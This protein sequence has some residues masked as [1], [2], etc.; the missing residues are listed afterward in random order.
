MKVLKKVLFFYFL[1][2]IFSLSVQ[3]K[4][5]TPIRIILHINSNISEGEYS[6]R[7]ISN[8]A[9]K[10]GIEGVIFTDKALLKWEYGIW[11]LRRIIKKTVEQPSVFNYGIKNYLED[12]SRLNKKFPDLVLIEGLEV[13]P[14]YYWEGSFFKG[15]LKMYNWHKHL[16]VLGLDEEGY[17]N[18][19]MIGNIRGLAKN[20]SFFKFW[21]L[22]IVGMGILFLN[23]KKYKY[24]DFQGRIWGEPLPGLNFLGIFLIGAGV[25]F[26]INN[27][28]FS[29]FRYTQYQGDLG[30]T[31]YQEFIDYVGERRGLVFWAEPEAESKGEFLGV[32]FESRP[33]IEEFLNTQGYT[34][35][36]VFYDGYREIG[37]P[38]GLWD[39]VLL[40]YCEEVRSHPVWAVGGLSFEKGDLA[41]A[42]K[43]LQTVVLAEKKGKSSVLSALKEGRAYVVRG[44]RS[45]DFFLEDFSLASDLG[46]EAT[47]GG[48]LSADKEVTINI[49]AKFLRQDFSEVQ[50]KLIKNGKVIK[51]SKIETPFSASFYDCNV[52]KSKSYYRLEI[53]AKGLHLITNPIFVKKVEL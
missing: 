42:I 14:F 24:K 44:I 3:S 20:F 29:D 27:W 22:V 40:E 51:E 18:L 8:I 28:P 39:R 50:L 12:I 16:L 32:Y 10:E 7:E 37:R 36:C 53:K 11:P 31:P 45:L 6:L 43:D 49:K 35:F 1:L 15:N 13:S 4:E 46:E 26:F 5:F 21:P 19:P 23:K 34:G 41:K 38:G 17:R 25:L 2:T 30:I 47:I 33:S 52:K 48:R 9:Q